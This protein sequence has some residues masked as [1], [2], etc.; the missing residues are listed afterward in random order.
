[1]AVST[2]HDIIR[3]TC[4]VIWDVVSPM[5]LP[6]PKAKDWKRIVFMDFTQGALHGKHVV[7]QAP[8]KLGSQ[9]FNCKGTF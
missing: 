1:M 7:M 2:V 4:Y 6:E 5:E 8:P 3:E 9:F